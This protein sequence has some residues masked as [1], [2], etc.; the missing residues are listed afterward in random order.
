MGCRKK[1]CTA[2]FFSAKLTTFANFH[3]KIQGVPKKIVHSDFFTPGPDK[4]LLQQQDST[5]LSAFA[6]EIQNK[7][8][9]T[10]TSTYT[11]AITI[12][13]TNKSM[14]A[15]MTKDENRNEYFRALALA[16]FLIVLRHLS[17]LET[18]QRYS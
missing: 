8:T 9:I 10:H 6:M 3:Q 1:R 7:S 15:P 11:I 4:K 5:S 18:V 13:N 16:P 14:Y 2:H 12:T 17:F